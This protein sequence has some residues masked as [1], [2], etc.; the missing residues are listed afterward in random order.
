MNWLPASTG[1]LIDAR[2]RRVWLDGSTIYSYP[3]GLTKDAEEVRGRRQEVPMESENDRAEVLERV[4]S[5]ERVNRRLWLVAFLL[6]LILAARD[7]SVLAGPAGTVVLEAD[8][9]VLKDADG[10]TRGD[11]MVDQQGRAKLTLYDKAGKPVAELPPS[12]A[13]PPAGR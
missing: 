1:S 9:F 10:A 6:G 4:R 7:R 13:L 3:Q 5:L 12:T 8:A 11:W 2:V